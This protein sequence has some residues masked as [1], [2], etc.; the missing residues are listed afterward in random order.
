MADDEYSKAKLLQFLN[1]LATKGL[2]N[3]HTAGSWKAA[4]ERL[5][6]DIEES[7]DVRTVDVPTAARRYHNKNP[8]LLSPGSLNAYEK[9]T[10]RSIEEFIKYTEAPSAYKAP[11]RPLGKPNGDK[12]KAKKGGAPEEAGNVDAQLT[13]HHIAARA[14][15]ITATVRAT[16]G[17]SLEFPMRPD[18]LAQIVVPRDMN[19]LEAKRLSRFI[20]SL[21][22]DAPE[23]DL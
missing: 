11:G 5:L 23:G 12:A 6:G 15:V 18:F 21:A 17:L 8:G 9:R 4:V 10:Q 2:V 20:L 13:S 3:S 16:P 1:M 19:T 14:G 7:A 22:H